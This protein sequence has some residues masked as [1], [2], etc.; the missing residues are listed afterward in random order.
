MP[1]TITAAEFAA[2]HGVSD[3][4][5][6]E[7][8]RKTFPEK[9]DAAGPHRVRWAVVIGS[10]DYRV[11]ERL[12]AGRASEASK[13]GPRSEPSLPPAVAALPTV[14]AKIRA[15]AAQGLERAAIARLLNIRYQHVRNV[16]LANEARKA[17]AEQ[18]RDPAGP[19]GDPLPARLV[20]VRLGP[21]GRVVVPAAFRDALGLTEGDVLFARLENGEVR[22]LPPAAALRRAQVIVRRHVPE[23]VSLVDELIAERR[24]EVDREVDRGQGRA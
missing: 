5:L 17:K 20:K 11:W 10:P 8:L 9:V 2:K 15:L 16:L 14:S 6:R 21:D 7:K 1:R 13:P 4:W 12:V 22:L 18:D 19:A 24:T 3:A 23:G